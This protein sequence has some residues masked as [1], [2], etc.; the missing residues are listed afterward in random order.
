MLIKSLSIRQ[1]KFA[2]FY[3]QNS[4]AKASATKAGYSQKAAHVTGCR[5]LKNDL[6]KARIKELHAEGWAAHGVSLDR[7]TFELSQAFFHDLALEDLNWSQKLIAGQLL[8][9]ILEYQSFEERLKRLE[10]FFEKGPIEK[11]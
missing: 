8:L 11:A 3:A 7:I 9:R 10:E 6:V 5:L 1:E 2:G 4:N